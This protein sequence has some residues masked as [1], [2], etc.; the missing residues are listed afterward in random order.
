MPRAGPPG[1]RHGEAYTD[2]D[3]GA[4]GAAAGQPAG[5]LC[6]SRLRQLHH[7]P[8]GAIL[9]YLPLRSYRIVISPFRPVSIPFL[10]DLAAHFEDEKHLCGLS[11]PDPNCAC[12]SALSPSAAEDTTTAQET[13]W[14][15]FLGFHNSKTTHVSAT[16]NPSD[17][18]TTPK[19]EA[20][21][22]SEATAA[23]RPPL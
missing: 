23:R 19:I 1:P 17:E 10:S 6:L 2:N 3:R 5:I 15:H 18:S 16:I 12:A 8:A 9:H 21:A 22:M 14:V 7:V 4:D 13:L 11:C 20:E